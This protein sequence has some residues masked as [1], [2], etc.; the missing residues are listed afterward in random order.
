M[1]YKKVSSTI[2]ISKELLANVDLRF[3]VKQI[4]DLTFNVKHIPDL[5]EMLTLEWPWKFRQGHILSHNESIHLYEN[6]ISNKWIKLL[7]R[8]VDTLTL[9]ISLT[10]KQKQKF[11]D[12]F[13]TLSWLQDCVVI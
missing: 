4:P 11:Q 6:L 8:W 13:L 9:Y 2:L 7:A 1:L 12:I 5:K 3:N 10:L